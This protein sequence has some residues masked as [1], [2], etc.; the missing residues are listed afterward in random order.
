MRAR[1][2]IAKVISIKSK[3]YAFLFYSYKWSMSKSAFPQ[4]D[5]R[6]III[7]IARCLLLD[8]FNLLYIPD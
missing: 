5:P 3:I 2:W 6:N 4:G 8:V 7:N 1:I